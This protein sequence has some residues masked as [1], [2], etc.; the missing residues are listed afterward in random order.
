MR[1]KAKE[2]DTRPYMKQSHIFLSRMNEARR[3][4][5]GAHHPQ[6]GFLVSGGWDGNWLASTEISEDGR[7]FRAHTPLPIRLS[8]HC[9]VA[10]VGDDG[11]FFLAGGSSWTY[12]RKV[13]IHR[14]S[15]WDEVEPMPTPRQCM[16]SNSKMQF[17]MN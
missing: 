17:K 9:M 16:K 14:G 13:F 15:Q 11:E 8:H 10:L 7:T 1:R 6:L 4:A 5:A 3:Y 12:S 2:L